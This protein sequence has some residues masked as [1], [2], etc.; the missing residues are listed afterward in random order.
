MGIGR[1]A[2]LAD[3]LVTRLQSAGRPSIV[4]VGVYSS[5]ILYRLHLFN[6]IK[7]AA[8]ALDDCGATRRLAALF[9]RIFLAGKL[10]YFFPCNCADWIRYDGGTS[11]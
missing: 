11:R 1:I 8:S 6:E 3:R 4:S 5:V 9:W 7:I 10:V 2:A